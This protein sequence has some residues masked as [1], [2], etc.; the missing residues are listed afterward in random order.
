M[1]ATKP[2]ARCLTAAG[3]VLGMTACGASGP[4]D[5]GMVALQLGT[6]ANGSAQVTPAT[7][8]L[9]SDVLVFTKVELVLKK[10]E[11]ERVD[12]DDCLGADDCEELEVG[13]LL[14][15]LPLGGGPERKLLVDVGAGV[16]DEVEFE[17]HKP[18]DSDAT[19][20][21]FL[22]NRPDLRQVSIRAVGTYNG[23]PFVWFTDL[24]AEQE[25]DLV[26][27][28]T[29]GG[30][31]AA[32]LTLLIDLGS[33][34]GNAGGTSLVGPSTALKGQPNEGLVKENVKRSFQAEC[35]D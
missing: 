31:S 30:G 11:L 4:S 13:P 6:R 9:G 8:T 26:P 16:F 1:F 19:D 5:G 35:D 15:E 7:I 22:A 23:A 3:V 17:I 34:F 24:N 29:V 33:W 32:E 14:V 12:E 10:I 25:L 2:M 18:E 21:A 27:P 20:A 28:M